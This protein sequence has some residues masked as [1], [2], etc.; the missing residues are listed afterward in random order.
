MPRLD[1]ALTVTIGAF[2]ACRLLLIRIHLWCARAPVSSRTLCP[3]LLQLLLQHLDMLHELFVDPLRLS[4]FAFL[5]CD[6]GLH[7]CAL[8]VPSIPRSFMGM[9]FKLEE[10]HYTCKVMLAW[11]LFSGPAL[12]QSSMRISP[13]AQAPA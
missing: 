6:L 7:L 3:L 4:R 8:N 5:L 1:I 10:A 13:P 9:P 12:R 11:L 2:V